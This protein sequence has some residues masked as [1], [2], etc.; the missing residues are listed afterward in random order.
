MKR[1]ARENTSLRRCAALVV[2]G[3]FVAN[4][5]CSLE[6]SDSGRAASGGT[7]ARLIE[8][9]TAP[10]SA[11]NVVASELVGR[12]TDH[13]ISVKASFD[14]S[15]E[16]YVEYGTSSGSYPNATSPEEF[17]DGN[18]ELVVS[19]L[20]RDT[21]YFYRL[22]Y[23]PAGSTGTFTQGVEYG[24]RTQRTRDETFTFDVQS[25]SH[26][27]YAAFYNGTLYDI[28]LA[29]VH[30]DSPDFLFDL[31]DTVSTDDPVETQ[32]SV[33]QKYLNQRTSLDAVGHTSPVFLVLGNHE[34]EEAW[35]LDDFGANVGS[36]LPVLGANGRKRYFL[37]P[38]PDD[39]YS[40][41]ADPLA[42]IDGDHLRGDY[43]AFEWGSALFVAIDPFW[44][45]QRK[46]YAGALGGEKDDEVVGDRWDWTLGK[47]QY[48]WLAQTLAQ[49]NAPFKFVFAHH[50]TGGT[51]DYVRG[52]VSGAKYCEWGG[53][54][55]DGTTWA[56]DTH[57][58]GWP[59]PVHDLLSEQGVTVF[60][61]GHDHVFAK[62]ELDGI[63]YQ[64]CPHAANASYDEGFS[65]NAVD[66]A[67]ADMVDNSGHLRVTVSPTL[68]RVEYVRAFLPGDGPNASVA[69]SYTISPCAAAKSDGRAC[70]D[71]DT[72]TENDRCASGVCT[73]TPRSCDDG[74]PC[75]DD[76]CD[77]SL[78]CTHATNL[79]SCD[80]GNACT[81]GDECRSGTCSGAPIT[82]STGDECH[83]AGACNPSDGSC[84]NPPLPD[85]S[86]CSAGLCF[87]GICTA[88]DGGGAGAA[89]EASN[90]GSDGGAGTSSG[91]EGGAGGEPVTAGSSHGGSTYGGA[92]H[93]GAGHGG[94]GRNGG[95][96]PSGGDENRA[97]G[98][99]HAGG[100]GPA[101]EPQA[102][103]PSD[104]NPEPTGTGGS[105]AN[106]SGGREPAPPTGGNGLNSRAGTGAG[107]A[108]PRKP[109]NERAGCDCAQAPTQ[110][111]AQGSFGSGLLGLALLLHLVSRRRSGLRG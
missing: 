2:G 43:Y 33:R 75:T 100:S 56:F 31:G 47:T 38:T 10:S 21:A 25:D 23:R 77:A 30:A 66:Y 37:N 46:P 67:N 19:G 36:S 84:S 51:S 91:S 45:T 65:T 74:N 5:G 82:C 60:F 106:A 28:T 27:G 70:D 11:L 104:I 79:A 22:R 50:P 110:G 16:A 71:G 111:R 85:R 64:E 87:G 39:F 72:C 52:G 93:G 94:S 58:P 89:G 83:G 17:D 102:G 14:A 68:V 76:D 105:T 97:T 9:V 86:P 96:T 57:R 3:V 18:I 20:T 32:T 55:V 81:T 95:S 4:A 53:Y 7:T 48:D 109:A 59:M 26:Q 103:A 49:S 73:G 24:F 107:G 108:Q 44:Y 92:S 88:P 12:P 98:G 8:A 40:G 62:E 99:T 35:N 101:P 63:V 78:G 34:N 1:L 90:A 61:H 42:A 54:D 69:Y 6:A 80:D 13:S 29:N 15:V 41:N